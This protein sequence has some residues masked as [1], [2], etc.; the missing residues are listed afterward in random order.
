MAFRV[1]AQ[2]CRCSSL[3]QLRQL[4]PWSQNTNLSNY[5]LNRYITSSSII[6]QQHQEQK[7][8]TS[9]AS[10]RAAKVKMR[11]TN[12]L[13]GNDSNEAADSKQESGLK[14]LFKRMFPIGR[15]GHF[16]D[17]H[18][19]ARD[20]DMLG[21]ISGT[22]LIPEDQADL[23]PRF[24]TTSLSTHRVVVQDEAK[25]YK[26][27]VVGV[28]FRE[29]ATTQV[30]SYIKPLQERLKRNVAQSNEIVYPSTSSFANIHHDQNVVI[31]NLVW[32]ETFVH[33]ALSG[34]AQSRLRHQVPEHEHDYV[35]SY[36]T[37]D[38]KLVSVLQ[39][40]NRLYGQVLLIDPKSRIRWR[41]SGMAT[42]QT[43]DIFLKNV[44]ELCGQ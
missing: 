28:M 3:T 39:T 12:L 7:P 29:I 44:N 31:F 11:G 42:P 2:G 32:N 25:K 26:A 43:L 8:N 16:D 6:S 10:D 40:T 18:E 5:G 23:L 15:T 33:Q 17:Y 35:L 19:F 27:C 41:A 14:R 38:P 36:N 22:D 24:K 34:W 30:E 1:Q 37:S 21:S 9:T 13:D 20:K 4:F